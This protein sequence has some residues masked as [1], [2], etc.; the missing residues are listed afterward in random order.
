V[1]GGRAIKYAEDNL[2][3][4]SVYERAQQLADEITVER[5]KLV[6]AR[7]QKVNAEE[8]Y[9]DAELAFIADMRADN[10][11][12]S[13]TAFEKFVKGK[14]HQNPNLRKM[15]GE[16]A[17]IAHRMDELEVD[18]RHLQNKLDVA[19]ARMGELGGYL[20]YLAE[21]K[22]AETATVGQDNWPPATA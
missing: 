21:V 7:H 5:G 13:Q 18:I 19:T 15:R 8:A 20:H 4:H 14:I 1:A 9:T 3:V 22:A 16:L 2:G 17:N 12:L 11:D 6:Q 10:P